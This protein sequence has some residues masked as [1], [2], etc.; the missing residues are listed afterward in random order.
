MSWRDTATPDAQADLDA[1]AAAAPGFAAHQ[2]GGVGQFFPYAAHLNVGG[3]IGLMAPDPELVGENPTS[4]VMLE[5]LEDVLGVNNA[6][7]R[8][9]AIVYDVNTVGG[10]AIAVNLEHREG[11]ALRMVIPYVR[12]ADGVQLQDPAGVE[13]IEAIVF[14]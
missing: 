2:L 10:E 7:L 1:L 8:A 5:T 9:S 4:T 14:R 6:Q 11:I 12:T 3:E 13:P